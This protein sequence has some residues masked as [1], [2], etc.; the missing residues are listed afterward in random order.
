M[1]MVSP[2]KV[3]MRLGESCKGYYSI[4][5]SQ[6]QFLAPPLSG[7]SEPLFPHL[8]SG[9]NICFTRVD[10]SSEMALLEPLA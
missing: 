2:I 9:S 10:V 4:T 1:Y 3:P 6:A 8:Q 5:Q 7:L